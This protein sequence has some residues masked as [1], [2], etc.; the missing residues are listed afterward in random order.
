MKTETFEPP[1]IIDHSEKAKE[2]LLAI[3]GEPLLYADW[4]RP[5]FMHYEVDA[6]RLQPY[7]PF[8]LDLRDG[9][10]YVSLVAFSIRGLRPAWGGRWT[11][12]M[13]SPIATHELLNVRTYVRHGNEPGIYFVSE[14]IPNRL[15]VLLGPRTFGLPY[16]LGRLEYR[17]RHEEAGG[18]FFGMVTAGA[19]KLRL[20]PFGYSQPGRAK[21]NSPPIHRWV[22]REYHKSRQGRQNTRESPDALFRPSGAFGLSA[23]HPAI[24]RWA[25]FGC[26]SGTKLQ[27]NIP[28]ALAL[29]YS[30]HSDPDP[31]STRNLLQCPAGSLSE[32]L[33]ERYT[34]FT[35]AS[36]RRKF[37]RVWHAPWLQ[38]EIEARVH[39]DSL[40]RANFPWFHD[41]KLVAA[42][43]SPGAEQVWMGRPHWVDH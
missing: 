1:G 22:S 34:A 39:D 33:L 23:R 9:K 26:P 12:W 38:M 30:A 17:H 42:N 18:R 14:W 13:L 4:L 19:A 28:K 10:A 43:Y 2:R 15:S 5:V 6:E 37:F 35:S 40:L 21:E 20:M 29:R 36:S 27:S 3:P 24:N 8:E 16:R 11:S 25:I 31:N 7:V 32:F 41:A